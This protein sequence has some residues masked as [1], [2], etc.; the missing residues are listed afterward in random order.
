M[1]VAAKA[2]EMQIFSSDILYQVNGLARRQ[3]PKKILRPREQFSGSNSTNEQ[4]LNH[5]AE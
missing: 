3:Q 2:G 5:I 1:S 4:R